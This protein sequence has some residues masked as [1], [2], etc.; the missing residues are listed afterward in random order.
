MR[1]PPIKPAT[2][3]AGM[4]IRPAHTYRAAR[5]EAQKALYRSLKR[6]MKS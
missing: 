5:R 6:A 3:V 2:R 1:M 4:N